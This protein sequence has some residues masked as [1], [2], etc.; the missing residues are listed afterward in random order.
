MVA[1]LI[2]T[3]IVQACSQAARVQ[4]DGV[5]ERL[6]ARFPDVAAMLTDAKEDVLAFASFPRAHW[7]KIW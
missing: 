7:T 3:I 6:E 4:L 1:A 2:R 5:A